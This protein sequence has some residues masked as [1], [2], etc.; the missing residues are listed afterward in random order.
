MGSRGGFQLRGWAMLL[1][2]LPAL[3][4]A[5]DR[6]NASSLNIV[7]LDA[8]RNNPFERRFR[9][10]SGCLAQMEAPK[11][12][13]IAYAT[14]PPSAKFPAAAAIE[15]AY[16]DSS[17]DSKDVADFSA[18]LE[19]YPDGQF[20]ALAKNRLAAASRVV[21]KDPAPDIAGSWHWSVK[22]I[23]VA[24]R[25]NT[26]TADGSCM[27]NTGITCIWSYLDLAARKIAFRF[28]DTWTHT[29]QLAEDGR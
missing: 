4:G 19:K 12:S 2:S 7:I 14:A 15:L 28:S 25:T 1:L 3:D 10:A 11:G 16:W 18:Y 23:F 24:D 17:K 26:V 8:C 21:R 20:V 27:L 13:L 5:L 29:M 9:G 22:T 6:L